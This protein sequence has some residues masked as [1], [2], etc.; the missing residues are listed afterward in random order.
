MDV[1]PF[2]LFDLEG[3]KVC[4]TKYDFDKYFIIDLWGK[5]GGLY[6]VKFKERYKKIKK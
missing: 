5:S 4:I 2:Y 3:D 6:D 1:F